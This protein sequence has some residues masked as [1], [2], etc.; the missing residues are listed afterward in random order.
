MGDVNLDPKLNGA[1]REVSRRHGDTTASSRNRGLA[2]EV[3]RRGYRPSGH[4][5]LRT[6]PAGQKP[7]PGPGL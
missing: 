4:H 2:E 6:Q 1:G 7:R 3:S 5:P